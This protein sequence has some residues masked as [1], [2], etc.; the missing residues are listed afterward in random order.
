MGLGAGGFLSRGDPREVR[1]VREL[2][3]VAGGGEES[4]GTG[5]R[6]GEEVRNSGQMVEDHDSLC[7]LVQ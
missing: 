1:G 7:H 2:Q 6:Q 3:N 4:C 5:G